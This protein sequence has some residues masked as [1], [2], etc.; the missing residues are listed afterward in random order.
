MKIN[1]LIVSGIAS[2]LLTTGANAWLLDGDNYTMLNAGFSA[3]TIEGEAITS[4]GIGL[5]LGRNLSPDWYASF[6]AEYAVYN[7]TTNDK[8]IDI[9]LK[10][11][12]IALKAGYRP[13]KTTLIYGLIGLSGKVN[14][15]GPV[16]GGGLRWDIADHLS[17]FGEYR[18]TSVSSSVGVN[19]AYVISSGVV[20]VQL[21][22]R[23]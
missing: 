16:F 8:N 7:I 17:L 19:N 6:L 13:M 21:Y 12:T 2:L 23:Y 18:R 5:E 9:G 22:F 10:A 4:Q 14:T 15:F 11:T 1:K 20:G 3:G